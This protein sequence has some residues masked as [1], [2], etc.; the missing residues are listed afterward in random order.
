MSETQEKKSLTSS[1]CSDEKSDD[2]LW[3]PWSNLETRALIRGVEEYGV[4]NWTAIKERFLTEL[5]NRSNINIKVSYLIIT[6]LF[7][8]YILTNF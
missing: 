7:S 2:S 4:G 5:K 1:Q 3:N 6:A 8:F